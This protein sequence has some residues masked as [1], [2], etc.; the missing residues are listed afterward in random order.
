MDVGRGSMAEVDALRV[1]ALAGQGGAEAEQDAQ[2]ELGRLVRTGRCG[3]D[4]LLANG[5]G[6]ACFDQGQRERA[7][8]QLPVLDQGLKHG[9]QAGQVRQQETEGSQIGQPPGLGHPQAEV[10]ESAD[11]GG[12]LQQLQGS[13]QGDAL[14]RIDQHPAGQ[15]R[16]A[17][18]R[19]RVET[20][21]FG[22]LEIVGQRCGAD[23][24]AGGDGGGIHPCLMHVKPG[25]R[26]GIG[27]S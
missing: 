7:A 1:P 17:K 11:F 18:Q 6:L 12:L 16:P 10:D 15:P 25:S 13:G 26:A 8:H 27:L 22:D 23:V 9:A 21:G 19:L 24:P 3:P 2:H 4:Q 5:R 20:R 14:L